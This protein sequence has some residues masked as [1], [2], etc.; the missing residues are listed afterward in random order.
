MGMPN[1]RKSEN[2]YGI[3]G[4]RLLKADVHVPQNRDVFKSPQGC[5]GTHPV[6]K[7]KSSRSVGKDN[8]LFALTA[9]LSVGLMHA[10][11]TGATPMGAQSQTQAASAT[12]SA[13]GPT[14][15]YEV[16]TIKPNKSD[17]AP[18]AMTTDDGI[19]MR[20]IPLGI[21]LGVAYGMSNDRITGGPEWLSDRYDISAKMGPD[22]A[23]ALK[24]MNPIDR[25]LAR[26]RMFQALLTERCKM[27]FHR[28]TKELPVYLL[29]V[30]KGGSK[31]QQGKPAD[32]SPDGVGG[33]GTLQ[34]GQG[35]LMTFKAMP[36]SALIQILAQQVGRAVL[37]NTGLTG[38]Y[39]FT[40]QF[41]LNASPGG[42]RGGANPAASGDS[43][44]ASIFT[45]LQEELGLK[46]DSGKGPVEV[47][48][49]DHIERP[50]DN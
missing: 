50:S 23:D 1:M 38:R 32:A 25:R 19:D 31:L 47:I 3:R 18:A 36:L 27:V 10:T 14:M 43:E 22:V 30:A 34:F 11:P 28:D 7:D 15:E 26:Q 17:I 24:K 41:N 29:V 46:L 4:L 45:I 48:V 33:T 42:G 49:I 44:P 20:N 8:L 5:R 35:G 13:A 40:W 12:A 2:N 6:G 37:D 9:L 39:D 16:A 21:L